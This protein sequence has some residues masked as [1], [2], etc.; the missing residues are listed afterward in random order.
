MEWWWECENDDNPKSC[1][2]LYLL[3]QT[4]LDVETGAKLK[5]RSDSRVFLC[6]LWC[7]CGECLVHKDFLLTVA[8]FSWSGPF[9][10]R[11]VSFPPQSRNNQKTKTEKRSDLFSD[12]FN[13]RFVFKMSFKQVQ[14]S[15]LLKWL[16]LVYSKV[17]RWFNL[18]KA[19]FA[20]KKKNHFNMFFLLRGVQS[21]RPD[22]YL[23]KSLTF[24]DSSCYSAASDDALSNAALH[25]KGSTVT[26]FC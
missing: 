18:V 25:L 12:G 22:S 5:I 9:I 8:F 21:M 20:L 4:S 26:S 16:W 6:E 24:K 3:R 14:R 11:R 10:K 13:K 2:T 23:C 7:V 15:F 1:Y 19:T 17:S